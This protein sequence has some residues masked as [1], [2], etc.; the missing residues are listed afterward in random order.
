MSCWDSVSPWSQW[1]PSRLLI[2]AIADMGVKK[3]S[4]SAMLM[5]MWISATPLKISMEVCFK[6]KKPIKNQKTKNLFKITTWPS[7]HTWA[8]NQRNLS[9][10]Y[11]GNTHTVTFIQ[12][13]SSYNGKGMEAAHMPIKRWLCS[14]DVICTHAGL[15]LSS[16]KTRSYELSSKWM[17]LENLYW[18]RSLNPH[19]TN[20][21]YFLSHEDLFN[22]GCLTWRTPG[23]QEPRTE[24]EEQYLRGD[25]RTQ[26]K[27]CKKNT[28]S[29]KVCAG[30]R[31]RRLEGWGWGRLT[32]KKGV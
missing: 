3:E 28:V 17:E 5:E 14:E 24:T 31:Y 13:C 20:T 22:L 18:M 6:K 9:I 19:R 25:D 10:P 16:E 29:G 7:L 12:W 11:G 15:W 1:P 30:G 2:P 32:G 27:V 23:S 8:H 4:P 26:V 21:V